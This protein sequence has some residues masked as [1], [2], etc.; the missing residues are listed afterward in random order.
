LARLNINTKLNEEKDI[1]KE[2]LE[3]KPKKSEKKIR[4]NGQHGQ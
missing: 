1:L 2:N 4:K 3:K